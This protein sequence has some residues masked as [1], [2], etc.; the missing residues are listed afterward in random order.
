M[1]G[2][3]NKTKDTNAGHSINYSESAEWLKFTSVV[4]DDVGDSPKS[5]ENKDVYFWVAE[6]PK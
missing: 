5:W 1:V 6:E 3:H 4:G 2:S